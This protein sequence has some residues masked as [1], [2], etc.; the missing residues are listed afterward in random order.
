[1]AEAETLVEK[2]VGGLLAEFL[3][4]YLELGFSFFPVEWGQKAPPLLE[5]KEF[6]SRKPSREEVE[7]WL[8]KYAVFNVAVACG[9]VSNLFVVDFDSEEAYESWKRSLP[10]DLLDLVRSACW[11]VKTGKGYHVYVR[12][13]DPELVP[14]TRIR[15]RE[16]IDI[17]GEGSYVIAPP[18]KHP[19][20]ASYEGWNSLWPSL[21]P[22]KREIV[23]RLLASLQP[24]LAVEEKQVEPKKEEAPKPVPKPPA[25][26]RELDDGKLEE[27]YGIL[28][29]FYEPGSRHKMLLGL[30]GLAA[31]LGVSPVSIAKIVKRLH[32]ETNDERDIRTR[33][34][35]IVYSYA[36]VGV[37]VDKKALAEVLGAEPYGPSEPQP[38]PVVG[39]S[40]LYEVFKAKVGEE[41]ARKLLARVKRL[42]APPPLRIPVE[43]VIGEGGREARAWLVVRWRG[44]RIEVFLRRRAG[45]GFVER[46]FAVLP[47]IAFLRDLAT[48]NVFYL[49]RE[50]DRVVAISTD[51][52]GLLRQLVA[53][54]YVS[55]TTLG[56]TN[57][58]LLLR[59]VMR[60]EEGE[61][62]PG[63]GLDGFHDPYGWGFDLADRG[64]SGLLEVKEWI[65][66]YPPSNRRVALAD[67][68]LFLAKLLTPAVRRMNPTFVD[69]LVWNY[70][71]GGEGKTTLVNLALLPLI[72]LDPSDDRP[73]VKITGAVETSAQM[74]FL[75]SVNR[76]PLVLDEQTL[77][78]LEKNAHIILSVSVGYGTFKIHAPRYG[79]L[80]EV[81]FKNQ[82][83][84]IVFTNTEFAR[85]LRRVR[86]VASDFAFAR[87]VLPLRWE[88]ESIDRK[89]FE[90]PPRPEP[91]LG[92]VE[93][94]WLGHREELAKSKDVAELAAKLME[95]L[96][97]EYGADL[98]AYV[99]AVREV[100]EEW[101]RER[102]SVKV[103]DVDIARERAYEIARQQLGATGLTGAK[104]LLSILENPDAYG[105]KLMK[106]KDSK[107]LAEE[108]EKLKDLAQRLAQY[109]GTRQLADA[110]YYLEAEGVTRIVLKADSPLVPGAPRQFLGAEKHQYKF[111]DGYAHGY[112]LPITRFA[113]IFLLSAIDE[114]P[115]GSQNS[116]VMGVNGDE[117][118]ATRSRNGGEV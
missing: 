115:W 90:D 10:P 58:Q 46:P 47:E 65:E 55:K 27:L 110:L 113:E 39:S 60:R 54:G 112:A 107:A 18:S 93:R 51:L 89:A 32:D 59:A 80:G 66:Y 41:E 37:P 35:C 15:C 24:A 6:Q 44:D 38:Q 103:T 70:G 114:E 108:R 77:P 75:V 14:K 97:G 99:R 17:K 50:E 19:S 28:R 25:E 29:P 9:R 86:H 49:A 36:R 85:W 67:V 53:Q 73:L 7:A 118:S 43:W 81:R 42:L 98:S 71:L 45:K 64:V 102:D 30:S 104:V 91:V 23:E 105:V 40:A 8:S 5:W 13:E 2:P 87:R 56:D 3:K 84:V 57:L 12:P 109:E 11:I 52:E 72:G 4:A 22:L 88:N 76:L 33:G 68:A 16:G 82:R 79:A 62:A 74:A 100:V 96:G 26:L 92:A 116:G 61:L 63:F 1:M 21:A 20:G 48:G 117:L 83:G 101:S 106:P 111:G 31:K 34:G 94:V 95:L 69:S 78:N